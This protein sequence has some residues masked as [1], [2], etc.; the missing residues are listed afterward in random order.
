[1]ITKKWSVTCARP[2]LTKL[3]KRKR[4]T[5]PK[6]YPKEVQLALDNIAKK[7]GQDAILTQDAFTDANIDSI[8]TGCIPLDEALGVGGLPKGRVIE[9][10]GGEALGKS[11]IAQCVVAQCQRNGGVAAYIDAEHALDPEWATHLGVNIDDWILVQPSWGEQGLDI[12]RDLIKSGGVDVV[13][14]DSVAALT[15]KDELDG[16]LT[17]AQVALQPRMMSK[18]MRLL[19]ADVHASGTCLIFLNQMRAKIGF[20]QSGKKSTGGD[21]LPFY[22]SVRIELKRTGNY[23]EGQDVMGSKIEAKIVKNKVAPAYKVAKY[24]LIAGVGFDNYAIVVDRAVDMDILMRKGTWV[25]YK[26]INQE[27]GEIEKGKPL[28]NGMKS[29]RQYLIDNPGEYQDLYDQVTSKENT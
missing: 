21:A 6:D 2:L 16:D 1:M 20:M 24:N 15:P 3:R 11:L 25:Y 10:F 7:Y 9:I 27:T 19:T 14:I 29:I 22:A 5:V 18:A 26:N 8:P 13:V 28:G 12:A 17:D 4:F 23:M